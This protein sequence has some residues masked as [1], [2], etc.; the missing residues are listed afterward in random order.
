MVSVPAKATGASEVSVGSVH[1]ESDAS[2]AVEL[3]VSGTAVPN[4]TVAIESSNTKQRPAYP[5]K[6][7]IDQD[8]AAK[9]KE[10]KI[11]L[12]GKSHNTT[13][14]K[15]GATEPNQPE[16][17][18]PENKSERA[19]CNFL[20]AVRGQDSPRSQVVDDILIAM[21][22]D[23]IVVRTGWNEDRYL[24]W[25]EFRVFHALDGDRF[26]VAMEAL[27]DLPIGTTWPG[28][29]TRNLRGFANDNMVMKVDLLLSGSSKNDNLLKLWV[30]CAIF[31][32]RNPE[33]PIPV[34]MQPDTATDPGV[35]GAIE[36][37]RSKIE[38][39]NKEWTRQCKECKLEWR[40]PKT[41]QDFLQNRCTTRERQTSEGEFHGS[42]D[43][44]RM[45]EA[46]M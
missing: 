33:Y 25:E 32:A 18:E 21:K 6:R 46:K 16:S 22:K 28:G 27:M 15:S 14:I 35:A 7:D 30:H 13:E 19:V 34:C 17:N 4:A 3:S 40:T 20:T 10:I 23:R 44:V 29:H 43:D 39:R 5:L 11:L 24:T 1:L 42:D 26:K 8:S 38:P 45:Q 37:S 31:L 41:P 12:N 9:K 2:G 36:P